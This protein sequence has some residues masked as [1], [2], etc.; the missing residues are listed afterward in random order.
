[1]NIKYLY[2][3]FLLTLVLLASTKSRFLAPDKLIVGSWEEVSWEYEK[4]NHK[5]GSSFEI[6][7]K[8]KQEITKNLVI[9]QSETWEFNDDGSLIFYDG[10]KVKESLA[11]NVKGRG[12]ILELIHNNKT[13]EDYEIQEIT[14]DSLVIHFH[15]DL[16]VRGIVKLTFK[17]KRTEKYAQEIQQP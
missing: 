9:H 12:N 1:M 3:V 4:V 10:E 11:W 16:Q 2:I 6:D 14:K 15:S 7:E 17:R 8:Q 13:L 5:G